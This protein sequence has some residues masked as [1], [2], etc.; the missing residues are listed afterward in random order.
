MASVGKLYCFETMRQTKTIKSVCALAG[1]EIEIAAEY[2]HHEDNKKPE[3]LAKFPHGKIPAFE[4]ANGLNLTEGAP[5]ARYLASLAPNSGLLG[6]TPEDAA[7][8]DQWVHFAETEIAAPVHLIGEM[9]MNF[10]PY[11]KGIHTVAAERQL[12]SLITLEAHLSTRTFLVGDRITLADIT[13]ASVLQRVVAITADA[14][15]R[16][17]LVN[18]VRFLETIVHQPKLE[19]IFG[20]IEYTEKALQYVPP[21]KEKAPAPPAA[22]PKEKKEKPKKVVEDDDEDDGNLVPEE[23]KQKSPLELLPKST[24]NLEDW[25]RAYSNKDTRG[26]DGALEW[27]YANFDKEGFSVWRV[28]F[29]YNEELTQVFMSSNQ[30]GGFFN[31]LEASRKYLFGSMGVLGE[32]NA[33]VIS[34]VLILRG[35]DSKLAVDCAPDFESYEYTKLDVF[36]NQE[37]KAFFEGALA[38][39]LEVAGKKWADGKNF[40]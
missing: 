10:L 8:V 38:W 34:G 17:N 33:S 36:D 28:D 19:A 39:D 32:N 14:A 6:S 37:D 5:I 40:K 16:A 13:A 26:A 23:P 22:A 12:R 31:R 20:P 7:V 18:T 9:L 30:I 15:V 35:Q 24:F 2:K 11:S 4:G 3:F 29:K 1:L 27:F 25:K 21:K